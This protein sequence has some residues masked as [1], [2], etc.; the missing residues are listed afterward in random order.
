MLSPARASPPI[1]EG[2]GVAELLK[3]LGSRRQP[4]LFAAGAAILLINVAILAW[5]SQ[6]AQSQ[7]KL[8]SHSL[9]VENRLS[10]LL[11]FLRTAES[12]QRAYI[13]A[14]D[15]AA[16]RASYF[17]AIGAIPGRVAEIQSM[18]ADNSAQQSELTAL[19]PMIRD[20]L[21]DLAVK[22]RLLEA[23]DM[24]GSVDLFSRDR[25][26]KLMAGIKERIARMQAREG[27]LLPARSADFERLSRQ[28]LLVGLFDSFLIFLL[29]WL[30]TAFSLRSRQSL[31]T[32]KAALEA[33]VEERVAE[34]RESNAE[35]QG[36]AYIVGHDLRSPLVN[37]MGFTSELQALRHAIFEH[38]DAGGET[39]TGAP[40]DDKTVAAE[41][42]EAI[43][44]IKAATAK[45]DR[46]I[47]AIL[48]LSREGKRELKP[49]NIDMTT[50]V[51]GVVTTLA[52]DAQT[53][54]AEI[55]VGNLPSIT[56]DRFALEQVF[57]NLLDNALKYLRPGE[58][59]RI[60]V[61]GYANSGRLIYEVRDNG[62]GIAE[63]DQTR[64]FE[65]FRRAG[66]QDQRGE[67]IGLAHVRALVRRLG[68]RIKLVSEP[69]SGSTFRVI[70]PRAFTD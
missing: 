55:E 57:S 2:V 22:V 69:N 31:E 19:E 13:L 28:L 43:G 1:G 23:G 42:D 27:Q 58:P 59:G 46:L 45:M 17:E 66:A 4:I 47:S 16:Y 62:R 53:V 65:L 37:I 51:D 20:K 24:T 35:M 67:G 41:F 50:L 40:I 10:E 39:S 18:L 30:A 33:K 44:F 14:S 38:L 8:A 15:K 68:G 60:Q 26:R 64:V 29:G 36:F 70:L 6:Q 32:A 54:G 5:T 34:L 48:S 56:C 7:S 21:E 3:R 25:G 12:E 61:T 63:A 11:L 49:E 9:Q 52:H